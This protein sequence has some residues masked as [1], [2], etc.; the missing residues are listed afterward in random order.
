MLEYA[1]LVVSVFVKVRGRERNAS[2]VGQAADHKMEELILLYLIHCQRTVKSVFFSQ[3][4][5]QKLEYIVS[6]LF[7]EKSNTVLDYKVNICN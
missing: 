2:A 4:T 1:S 7:F 6:S 3:M 5:V